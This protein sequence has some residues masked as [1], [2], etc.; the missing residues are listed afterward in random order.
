MIN[1]T[2]DFASDF[3]GFCVRGQSPDIT[4][5]RLHARTFCFRLGELAQFPC[6]VYLDQDGKILDRE[7]FK[8]VTFEAEPFVDVAELAP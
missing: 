8:G 7:R 3:G 1:W 6:V 5:A 4:K 2:I